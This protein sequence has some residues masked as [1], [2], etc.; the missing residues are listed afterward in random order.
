MPE[1]FVFVI[2]GILLLLFLAIFLRNRKYEA[3]RFAE[4]ERISVTL[5]FKYTKQAGLDTIADCDHIP[6]FD[7][8]RKKRIRN[9]LQGGGSDT[10]RFFFDYAFTT[11]GGQHSHT[12]SQSVA[13]VQFER[14]LP[15]FELRPEHLFHKIGAA[16]GY[17]DIDFDSSPEFSRHYL[18]RGQDETAIRSLFSPSVRHFLE[19][20]LG[21]SIEGGGRWMIFYRDGKRVA[22]TELSAFLET[23]ERAFHALAGR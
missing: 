4:L 8:G 7:R 12:R 22:P 5:G 1:H 23:S 10:E 3:K 11:G 17:Q 18:L 6:L 19:R 16:L 21:W 13:L 20:N 9:L 15:T 14:D 2:I